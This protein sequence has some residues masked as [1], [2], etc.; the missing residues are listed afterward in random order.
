V[1]LKYDG[2]E[3]LDEAINNFKKNYSKLDKKGMS[4]EEIYRKNKR[5]EKLEKTQNHSESNKKENNK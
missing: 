3:G 1:V 2:K 4:P 5:Q